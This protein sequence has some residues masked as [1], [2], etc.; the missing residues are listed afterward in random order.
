ME[1]KEIKLI[2]IALQDL[3]FETSIHTSYGVYFIGLGINAI[4]L[5]QANQLFNRLPDKYKI[6][7]YSALSEYELFIRTYITIS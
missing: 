1:N 3:G 2:V 6:G 5:R 4:T 7:R